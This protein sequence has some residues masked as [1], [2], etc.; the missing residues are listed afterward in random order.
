M[1]CETSLFYQLDSKQ[2]SVL[3]VN[4]Q[5]NLISLSSLLLFLSI[6][7]AFIATCWKSPK[8]GRKEAGLHGNQEEKCRIHS[9]S[10]YC[11]K[12][13]ILSINMDASGACPKQQDIMYPVSPDRGPEDIPSHLGGECRRTVQ[14]T[15]R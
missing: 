9:Y 13:G 2:M 6:N 3:S 14:T 4:I 7:R 11:G 15:E 5:Q 1:G 10:L 8:L 12:I